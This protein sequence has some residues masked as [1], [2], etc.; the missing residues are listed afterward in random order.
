MILEREKELQ[1]LESA[2]EKASRGN[3][4]LV[5]ICG[6]AGIGKTRLIEYFVE[7]QQEPMRF[8]RGACDPFSIPHPLCP[9]ID[10]AR[11]IPDEELSQMLWQPS[12]PIIFHACIAKIQTVT[13][14][15]IVV[16]EDIHWADEATYDLMIYLGRRIQETNCLMIITYRND[17]LPSDHPIRNVVGRLS[18]HHIERLS[19]QSLSK[20]TVVSL[21]NEAPISGEQLYQLTDGNPFYVTE[22]LEH[23]TNN[24]PH[25]V[26]ESIVARFIQQPP[27]VRKILEFAAIIPKKTCN[28]WHLKAVWDVPLEVFEQ[29]A[30]SGL[31]DI[32]ANGLVFRHA[33]MR[34]A[35]AESLPSIRRKMLHML[36][37]EGLIKSH[38]QGIN[39]GFT[40]IVYH[41]EIINEIPT[42]LKYAPMAAQEA[43]NLG[44]HQEA[45]NHY[46]I[47]L[48][49]IDK[50]DT[51]NRANIHDALAYEC[52][53]TGQ[54]DESRQNG[55]LALQIWRQHQQIT[56]EANTLRQLSRFH[57]FLGNRSLAEDY[58]EQALAIAT[59]LPDS[60]E[61]AL[62]YSNRSQLYMLKSEN[63]QA[64]AYGEKA[65]ELAKSLQSYGVMSHA[66][67][68]MGTAQW[69]SGDKQGLSNLIK[70]LQ[71]A[72]EHQL[73]EHVARAYTNITSLSV[74][75]C[76]Y[77]IALPHFDA[78]LAYCE[79]QSLASWDI[80]MRGWLARCYFEQG[81]WQDAQAEV[82]KI[83]EVKTAPLAI[84]QPALL[85][86]AYIAIR[87][88]D[89]NAQEVMHDAWSIA[90][91]MQ[92]IARI[93][94][95]LAIRAEAAWLKDTL[96]NMIDELADYYQMVLAYTDKWQIG[97]IA[98]WLWKAGKLDKLPDLIAEP[99]LYQIKG[100]WQAA[101]DLWG[102]LGC[103][104]EKAFALQHGDG[105]AQIHALK[106][107]ESLGA[108]PATQR[109][110]NAMRE[111]GIYGPHRET[112]ANPAGLTKRQMQVLEL[113]V[114]GMTDAEIAE[115]L[116]ISSKTT[117][118]HVSAIL[119]KFDVRTRHEAASYAVKQKWIALQSSDDGGS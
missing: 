88:G 117:G 33:L 16:F 43:I 83:L 108:Q 107:F 34:Q 104:Y 98:F 50:L 28:Y 101:A 10:I 53:L 78:G 12:R 57:W 63:A 46:R 68:N 24:L 11:Q 52:Y 93:I 62:A 6:E 80:Y 110:R 8:L 14:P 99:Y 7:S 73:E 30:A 40:H 1:V 64:I 89:A 59:T 74:R 36:A 54:L 32:E 15:T 9:L 111:N 105:E 71:L 38:E 41:A 44:A 112:R 79:R 42:I 17:A 20:D 75:N 100:E 13:Q 76:Q 82:V 86:K 60:I 92:E 26:S 61:L 49:H 85:T 72:E 27:D 87:Q 69:A 116:Y 35:I 47:M 118:H 29:C 48:N 23:N 97:V 94:P 37:I 5:I 66:L 96:Q 103:P 115:S 18:G 102:E 67:N 45:A 114:K 65:L 21:A 31:V 109:L 22:F 25:S 4:Q 56:K 55:E 84:R 91:E 119:S 106:I 90:H 95:T 77:E 70:S 58:A 81:Q 3:G 2:L 113:L 39:I 19:L 51:M